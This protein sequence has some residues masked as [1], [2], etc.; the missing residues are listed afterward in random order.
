MSAIDEISLDG[1]NSI[2]NEPIGNVRGAA[3][4]SNIPASQ[5]NEPIKEDAHTPDLVDY[6]SNLQNDTSAHM[7]DSH[8][9]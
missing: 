8:N 9:V 2:V 7:L 5:Q 3:A 1:S 4:A 6:A